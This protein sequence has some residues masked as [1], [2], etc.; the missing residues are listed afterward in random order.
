MGNRSELLFEVIYKM[1]GQKQQKRE[2][3]LWKELPGE[4]KKILGEAMNAGIPRDEAK[5]LLL[6]MGP[7]NL[8]LAEYADAA[9]DFSAQ[10]LVYGKELLYSSEN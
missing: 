6:V 9:N 4:L 5:Y 8:C 10:Y 2:S 1:L 3:R 7:V